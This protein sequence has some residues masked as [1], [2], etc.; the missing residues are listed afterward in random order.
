[1]ASQ[2]ASRSLSLADL[3]IVDADSHVGPGPE[4]LVEY[5]DESNA[6]RRIIEEGDMGSEVMTCTRVTPAFPN[7]SGGY[8]D[9][10]SVVPGGADSPEGKL[11][12]MDEFGL[13]Y[14]ILTPGSGLGT[15]N[16][17]Q[18]AVA[19]ANAYNSWLLD[20][21]VGVDDRLCASALVAHQVPERAAEEVER[22]AGEDSIV[23]VQMPTAGQIPPAGHWSY[24]PIYET[25]QDHGLPIV[26]H[27]ADQTSAVTFPVQHR[28]AETFTE[29]HAFSFPVEGMWHLISLVCNGVPERFPDLEFV[30]QEPGFEW[31]PWMMWRLDDHYLQNSQDLP[32]L[33]KRPSEYIRDQFYFTTQPLGHTED[34]QHMGWAMEMA[35]GAD[36][37]LF[38]TD[39][40]HP[41]FDPPEEA[42]QPAKTQLDEDGLRGVMGE[43]ACE[44]FG[45]V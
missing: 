25:A 34:H 41:D 26:L 15:V 29:N 18:T 2:Q 22:M 35:G 40:P 5:I 12:Y 4:T 13:D 27:T 20:K 17:D 8:E 14:S 31:V 42:F 9:E 28:W 6:A 44:V 3:T 7:D 30:F 32:M 39:H 38:A 24:D 19:W 23:G 21:W 16:H 45:L 1:M 36:T 11:A 43:T 33:T 10:N 37:L